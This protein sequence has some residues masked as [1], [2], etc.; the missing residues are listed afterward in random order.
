MAELMAPRKMWATTANKFTSLSWWVRDKWKFTRQPKTVPRANRSD[1]C[2]TILQRFVAYIIS[3]Y[4]RNKLCLRL[5]VSFFP[6][7]R[8]CCCLASFLFPLNELRETGFVCCLVTFTIRDCKSPRTFPYLTPARIINTKRWFKICTTMSLSCTFSEP[9]W[10]R[11]TSLN[12][13][14]LEDG[15]NWKVKLKN[16]CKR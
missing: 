2:E 7:S 10:V 6:L 8:S 3:S 14:T 1:S 15:E 9:S 5:Q 4:S 13:Y 11:S 16:E 12:P